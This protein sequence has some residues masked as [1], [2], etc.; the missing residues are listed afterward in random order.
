MYK[1]IWGALLNPL[2]KEIQCK[3]QNRNACKCIYTVKLSPIQPETDIRYFTLPKRLLLWLAEEQWSHRVVCWV[4]GDG[5]LGRHISQNKVSPRAQERISP[6]SETM[7]RL[8]SLKISISLY[9]LPPNM[10]NQFVMA[11]AC[12]APMRLHY[13]SLSFGKEIASYGFNCHLATTM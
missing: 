5:F 12:W 3:A 1:L 9:A 6:A 7:A 11:K 8:H 2:L 4:W 10:S 13:S